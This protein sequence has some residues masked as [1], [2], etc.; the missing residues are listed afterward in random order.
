MPAPLYEVI[1]RDGKVTKACWRCPDCRHPFASRKSA[2]YH[3]N[4]KP[5][6]HG[7]LCRAVKKHPTQ[8]NTAFKA[9]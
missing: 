8:A 7:G 5:G 6:V 4:G 1:E 3:I 9:A 2:D